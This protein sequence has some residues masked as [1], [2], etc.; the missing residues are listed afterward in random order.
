MAPVELRQQFGRQLR[1][2]G[3]I[4]KRQV[5]LGPEAIDAELQRN[6]PLIEEG[7]FVPAIDH[8]VPADVS[9]DNYRYFIEKLMKAL[10]I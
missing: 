6:R 10:E 9:F 3:G 8:S 5:A 2:G 7:G 4:D 1:L